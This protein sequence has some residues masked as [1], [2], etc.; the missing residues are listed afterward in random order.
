MTSAILAIAEESGESEPPAE[1]RSR[2]FI[3]LTLSTASNTQSID[4][5]WSGKEAVERDRDLPE[6]SPLDASTRT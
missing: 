3:P 5:A 4:L 6:N 1:A 2:S